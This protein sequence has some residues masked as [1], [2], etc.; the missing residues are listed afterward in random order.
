MA[1]RSL[2]ALLAVIALTLLAG[3]GKGASDKL[4]PPSAE[5]VRN[6]EEALT[7]LESRMTSLE[8]S[9][10]ELQSLSNAVNSISSQVAQLRQELDFY[11]ANYG[12][13]T[14]MTTTKGERAD[15]LTKVLVFL[16]GVVVAL[17]VYLGAR[18]FR[19]YDEGELPAEAYTPGMTTSAPPADDE[20]PPG[21]PG[22][23]SPP[24]P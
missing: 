10:E 2:I 4:A 5:E 17:I 18:L 13:P 16:L 6:R 15:W 22:G 8:K 14:A 9:V 21:A 7:R 11:V 3:C 19:G 1:R 23:G 24:H 12:Q 20:P